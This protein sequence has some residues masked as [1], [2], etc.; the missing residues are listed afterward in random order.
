MQAYSPLRGNDQLY[1]PTLLLNPSADAA[2]EI[3]R[4]AQTLTDIAM[5]YGATSAAIMLAWLLRPPSGIVPIIG[6]SKPEHIIDNCAADRITLSRQ[7]WT[8][9]LYAAKAIQ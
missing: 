3:K 5:K 7:E 1:T 6:A 4:V 2:P 9:L 8:T